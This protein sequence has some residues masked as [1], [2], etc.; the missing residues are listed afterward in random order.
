M[1]VL[2]FWLS[3]LFV[4][5]SAFGQRR[6]PPKIKADTIS[7]VTPDSAA[8]ADT[9]AGA[10][11]EADSAI[12]PWVYQPRLGFERVATDSLLRWELWSSLTDRLARQPG[13]LSY[14]LGGLGREHAVWMNGYAPRYQQLS[15]E[16]IT[17]GDPITGL[18]NWHDIP[19][20]QLYAL[21]A[22]YD[23]AQYKTDFTTQRYYLNKPVTKLNYDESSHRYRSLEFTVSENI[24]RTTN[25]TLN[26]WDRRD[27][28]AYN[29]FNMTGRQIW[30]EVHHL[31]T[32][33]SAVRIGVL[34]NKREQQESFGY[35][36]TN[37]ALFAFDRFEAIPVNQANSEVQ[38][39]TI[40]ADYFWRPDSTQ[41]AA[42][43]A[44]VYRKGFSR[45][46]F[47]SDTISVDVKSYGSNLKFQREWN[48]L[49]VAAEVSSEYSYVKSAQLSVDPDLTWWHHS[50]DTR[51]GF[52]LFDGLKL[53]TEGSVN[54]W[55]DEWYPGAQAKLS[56]QQNRWKLGAW[57]YWS[58]LRQPLWVTDWNGLTTPDTDKHSQARGV[59]GEI[60]I[61]LGDYLDIGG[62]THFR[63]VKHDWA[64]SD[65][66]VFVE[67]PEML[68]QTHSVFVSL[69]ARHVESEVSF[70]TRDIQPY[71]ETTL[72][73]QR[74]A[75]GGLQ[76]ILKGSMYWK[77][78][79]IRKAAY[80]K[81]GVVGQWI[82]IAYKAPYYQPE[83][84][85]WQWNHDQPAVPG[86]YRL[87]AELS[88]R[89]RSFLVL[90]RYENVLD[91]FGQA[92]YFET[93]P[94]PMPARRFMFGFRVVFNN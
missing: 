21:D 20:H 80:I 86:H 12:H 78:Y 36:M 11:V 53:S 75:D 8:M 34:N 7:I 25:V 1:V 9:L 19:H 93:I 61:P 22:S 33:R 31:L 73:A 81:A 6:N 29:Q 71:D 60:N 51:L 77:G 27:G 48:R 54:L 28:D 44:S 5:H 49:E 62:R 74:V 84:H 90:M 65:D 59:G 56:W 89:V 72:P 47:Q 2:A 35:V 92:G 16:G 41:P 64:Y 18:I 17:M 79:V 85:S 52:A 26:Y 46:L 50:A 63:V 15:W 14:R 32:D 3:T 70:T 4:V 91:G 66:S 88:A 55:R 76:M 30:G 67:L 82:P 43:Q 45:D 38:N 69:N 39:T 24:N 40:R 83:F 94:Y 23:D 42:F 37:P 87:D 13:M 10:E 68:H 57:A 58:E